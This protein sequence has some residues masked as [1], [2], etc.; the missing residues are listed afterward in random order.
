MEDFKVKLK[1]KLEAEMEVNVP[2]RYNHLSYKED[3]ANAE[4]DKLFAKYVNN[5][6]GLSYE[7]FKITDIDDVEVV[8]QW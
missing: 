7:D 2:I 6:N 1:I 8:G 5:P 3:I 4:A